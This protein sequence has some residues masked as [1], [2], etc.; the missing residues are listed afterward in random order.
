MKSTAVVLGLQIG[1]SLAIVTGIALL[2]VAAAF[3]AGGVLAIVFGVA[4]DR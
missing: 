3:I 4:A 1:G 2:N